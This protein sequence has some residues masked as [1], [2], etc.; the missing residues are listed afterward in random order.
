MQ[1]S[2]RTSTSDGRSSGRLSTPAPVVSSPDPSP[3]APYSM[4]ELT[5]LLHDQDHTIGE[6]KRTVDIL[7]QK[8]SKLEQLVVIK[9]Q[10]IEALLKKI[11]DSK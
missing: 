5:A 8:N 3:P 9:D 10:K 1:K 7:M 11:G 2:A 6:L 4:A